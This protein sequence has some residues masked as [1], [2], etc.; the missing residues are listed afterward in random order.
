VATGLLLVLGLAA[1][2]C[3]KKD[4]PSKSK[5]KPVDPVQAEADVLGRELFDIVD[6]VMAYK[7]AHS[8]KLPISL[9][10]AGIDSLTPTVIRR[11]DR[12]GAQPLV[13]IV[14]RRV[15]GRVVRSC[16]GTDDLQEDASLHEGAFTVTCRVADGG[17]RNFIVGKPP[18]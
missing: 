1:A 10:Q 11:Y 8:G 12:L 18:E 7:S 5:P 15:E 2:G 4:K 9:R 6:R 16:Q 17:S 14:Y 3:H 13:T